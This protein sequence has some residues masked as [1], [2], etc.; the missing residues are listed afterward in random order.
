MSSF[1]EDLTVTKISKRMWKVERGF[2]YYIGEE[3]SDNYVD[4]P[5]GFETDF[6]SVPRIFWIILPPAGE[7]TPAAVVHDSLYNTHL[8]DR[9]KADRVFLEAM[10]VLK[11]PLWKRRIM[12]RAVR[13]G[14]GF[15]WSRK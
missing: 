10:K 7:Y 1:T 15:V 12:Y 5:A 6:A 2:R 11:V 14:G 13:I 3:G 8:M 4:V 9:A